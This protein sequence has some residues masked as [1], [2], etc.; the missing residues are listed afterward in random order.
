MNFAKTFCKPGATVLVVPAGLPV[1]LQYNQFG[2][3]QKFTVGFNPTLDS[4]YQDEDTMG[5]GLSEDDFLYKEV[6]QALK[7]IVPNSISTTGGTTWIYGV[8]YTNRIPCDEGPLDKGL[9]RSY[10]EDIV[11]NN[12]YSFY[13]AYATSKAVSL[14]GLLVTKSFLGS[15]GFRLLPNVVVPVTMSDVTLHTML[16]VPTYPFNKNFI[17]GFFLYE[18][19]SCRYAASNLVQLKVTNNPEPYVEADGFL[20]GTVITSS[21]RPYVFDYSTI[22]HHSITKGCTLLA[23]HRLTDNRLTI[24]ATR[25]N[26]ESE[27]PVTDIGEDIVCPVCKKLYRVGTDDAPVQCDD[28]HCLSRSYNDAVKML[29]VLNLPSLPYETYRDWVTNK[30]IICLTDILEMSP[31]NETEIEAN[32]TTA[33]YAVIPTEVVPNYDVLDRFANKCNNKVETVKYYLENP[34][35]IETDLDITDPLVRRLAQWLSDPYNMTT[36]FTIFSQVKIISKRQKFDGAPIFRGNTLAVTGKFRRGDYPEIESILMSYAANV[37][38]SIELGQPLP[39]MVI[40][41]SLNEGISGQMIQKARSHN[42]PI[43]YED[44][45]FTQY[46]IDADLEQNLL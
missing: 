24:L 25:L 17:A 18:D 15:A 1:K 40:V 44:E 7:K 38:P 34:L 41:G 26:S 13:A 32:L 33:I 28:P 20:K 12:D 4:M 22:V 23:E 19:L 6:L 37:V 29:A 45:F 36:L 14:R 39:N 46:E 30:D 21:G 5:Q 31:Y 16:D 42:I 2:L 11:K 35:R 27:R 9:A 43:V 10:I 3:L 8:C